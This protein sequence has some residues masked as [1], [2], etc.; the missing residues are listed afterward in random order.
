M[1]Y[2]LHGD[3]VETSYLRLSL[4]VKTYPLHKKIKLVA[5]KD[6]KDDLYMAVFSQ[7]LFDNQKIIICEDFFNANQVSLESLNKIPQEKIVIFWEKGEIL[8]KNLKKIPQK[9]KIEHFKP[10]P[11]LFH[12]LDAIS[13]QVKSSLNLLAGFD[14]NKDYKLTWNF[15]NRILLLIL[16]KLGLNINKVSKIL[17][18]PIADWQWQK[19]TNQAKQFTLNDLYF[20]YSGAL[21]IDHMIKKGTT[22]MKETSLI[23]LLLLKRFKTV[24]K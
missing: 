10:Q 5:P 8:P 2:V 7:D 18:R 9:A 4:I 22:N 17:E 24:G 13:P 12:F 19:I 11:L 6:N 23:P 20:L 21:K 16:S 14:E 3:Q 15:T 1:I